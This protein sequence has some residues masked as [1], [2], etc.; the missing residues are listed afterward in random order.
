V[1]KIGTDKRAIIIF[2][3]AV[4]AYLQYNTI[5]FVT[6]PVILFCKIQSIE[7]YN[8]IKTKIINNEKPTHII[9]SC[10]YNN[11]NIIVFLALF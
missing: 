9:I 2:L 11:N 4:D 5:L 6:W 1:S 3:S 10:L 7:K 8:Y